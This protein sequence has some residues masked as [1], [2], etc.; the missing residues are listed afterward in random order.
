[1]QIGAGQFNIFQ[2]NAPAAALP[3]TDASPAIR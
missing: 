2:V 3:S 1:V